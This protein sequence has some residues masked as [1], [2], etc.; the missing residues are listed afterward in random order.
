VYGAALFRL[1][2]KDFGTLRHAGGGVSPEWPLQYSDF[3]PYYTRAEKL[4]NVHGRRGIDP[5]EPYMSREYPH[6]PVSHEPV[7][8]KLHHELERAG[9]HPFFIPLGLRLNEKNS[10]ESECIRCSTCDG[11][12]CFIHAKADADINCVRPAMKQ[13]KITLLTGMK[14]TRLHTNSAGTSITQVEAES[15]GKKFYYSADI[16]VVSCGAV[17][18]AVLFLQSASENHPEGLAN[19]SGQLG[20][21]LMKHQNAAM[22]AVSPKIN[23]SIFQKTLAVNDFYFG[24]NG[25]DFPM[26]HVQLL[27]KSSR[28]ILASDAPK[29]APGFILD[30]MARHSVDWWLTA[31]DLPDPDNRVTI[32]RGRIKL[33]YQDN[34]AE[35]FDRLILRWKQILRRLEILGKFPQPQIFLS[36]KIP[37]AG[38]GHQCGTMRLGTD[39]DSSVLDLNCKTH[40]LDNLYVV[41]GSFFVSSG[42]V[43]PSLTIMANALRVGDHIVERMK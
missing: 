41:D 1:R 19:H 21:N 18:S 27:G 24:E 40:Q 14:V 15:C 4:Y 38:L 16:V 29:L 8:E 42:A 37:L 13:S 35:G 17:N 31:E 7:I 26:G 43:N 11:F 32:D 3:E 20:R 33:Y 2:E 5:T 6:D 12:P 22:L 30:Q 9:Y 36:K 10:L 34:N 25:Y 23:N 39:P 28:E